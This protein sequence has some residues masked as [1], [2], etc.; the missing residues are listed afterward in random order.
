MV[1]QAEE[2]ELEVD[3]T[4]GSVPPSIPPSC[5]AESDDV[6]ALITRACTVVLEETQIQP[7]VEYARIKAVWDE[8]RHSWLQSPAC[9]EL[10]AILG[11]CCI[12][13]STKQ[14]LCFALGSFEALPPDPKFPGVSDNCCVD[15]LFDTSHMVQHAA[16][17]TMAAVLGENL[18]LGSPLAV[19]AQDPGYSPATKQL[20]AEEGI[21]VV[22][23]RGCLGF[24]LVDEDTVVYSCNAGVPV[25][26]IV[27]DVARPAAM[28]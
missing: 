15:G 6:K 24:A 13:E 20:L 27:A 11:G 23:G 3:C 14:I 26:Q 5:D 1:S 19:L 10:S 25:K 12:R 21:T 22:P 16:A 2:E 8:T 4:K 28:I 7:S 18:G 17:L 9:S